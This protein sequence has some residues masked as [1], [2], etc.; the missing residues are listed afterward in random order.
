MRAQLKRTDFP[1]RNEV[2]KGQNLI[3]EVQYEPNSGELSTQRGRRCGG[4]GK[5]YEDSRRYFIRQ[6][7]RWKGG[8]EEVRRNGLLSLTGNSARG[9]NVAQVRILQ[10]LALTAPRIVG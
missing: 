7:T 10:P 5:D 6:G 2:W 1:V 8:M 4:I 9:D 3:Q